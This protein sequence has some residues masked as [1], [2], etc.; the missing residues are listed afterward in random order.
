M[1]KQKIYLVLGIGTDVGKTFLVEKLCRILPSAMAIKP[2]VSGFRDDDKNSDPA[3]I[4]IALGQRIS[5]KNLDLIS[6]WR[7]EKAVSPHLAGKIN[8]LAVKKFCLKKIFEAK[9]Q[10][11]FLFIEAAGGVMTPIIKKKTFLF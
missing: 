3:K 8:F 5:Q 7:F 11:Q 4:L 2:I 10:N 6:P 9:S 1:L